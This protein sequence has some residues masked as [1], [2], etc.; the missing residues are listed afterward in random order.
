MDFSKYFEHEWYNKLKEYVESK[1]FLR[2]GLDI[3]IDR[4]TY[5]IYPLKDSDTLFKV[6][7]VVPYNKVKVVILGQD[8]YHNRPD[9]FDGLSFSNSLI[10][11]PQPSLVNIL[12]E[13]ENDIYDGFNID[14][15]TNYSLYNWAEQGVLLTNT[16]HTVIKDRPASH[17]KRWRKFTR[18]MIEALNDRDNIVWLLWGRHA[19]NYEE[20]IKNPSHRI[21]KTSHPSPLGYL[22]DAPIPFSGSKCF[23]KTNE[24]LREMNLKEIKW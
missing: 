14:R 21:I 2:I 18:L 22:K 8:P 15:L 3:N 5:V 9:A 17:M 10:D 7:R 13:V 4:K 16:A 20:F 11:K 12:E 6:F 24:Y 1:E 19:Q 23:S